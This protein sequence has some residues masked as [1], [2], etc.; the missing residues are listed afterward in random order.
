VPASRARTPS[1]RTA[2]TRTACGTTGTSVRPRRCTAR[3]R[4]HELLASAIQD[5]AGVL[6]RMRK[7]PGNA[8]LTDQQLLLK[9]AKGFLGA[10][11]R[12]EYDNALREIQLHGRDMGTLRGE[13]K[14]LGVSEGHIDDLVDL[15]F[16]VRPT[17]ADAG[18]AANLKFR[19][20]LDEGARLETPKG[21]LA[22]SDPARERR[23]RAGRRVRQLDGRPRGPR[24]ARHRLT[25]G[26]PARAE[27]GHRRGRGRGPQRLARRA[28]PEVAAELLQPTS[29]A[30]R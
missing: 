16:E 27:E 13:L 10:V 18:R 23:A 9:K 2:S 11:K 4:W 25:G 15:L 28:G 7:A 8:A 17:D 6:E 24:E 12:L 22:V 14:S 21:K 29:S 26:V 19:F 5:K 20:G 1:S 3:P 30:G